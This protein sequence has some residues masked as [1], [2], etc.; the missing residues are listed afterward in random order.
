MKIYVDA[1]ACPVKNIIIKVALKYKIEVI[2]VCDTS[3][4]ISDLYSKVITVDKSRDSADL[5]LINLVKK[6]DIV[7]TQDYGVACLAISKNAT[8]VSQNGIVYDSNNIDRLLF[9]RFLSKK[10]RMS[11][12]K[13]KNIP[14]RTKNDDFAFENVFNEIVMKGIEYESE[15]D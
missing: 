10:V 2:M 8:A 5:V 13:T 14:K 15:K 11:G 1:D 6:N 9:E 3:H 4:I 7:V 12:G